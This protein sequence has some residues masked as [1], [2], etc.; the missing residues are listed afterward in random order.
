MTIRSLAA[1]LVTAGLASA[2]LLA[3]RPTTLPETLC[4][5][6]NGDG[7]I[8]AAD[9]LVTLKAGVGIGTCPVPVC[10]VT[11]DGQVRAADALRILKRAVG[12]S[13]DLLC[14]A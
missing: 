5:D 2:T 14:A 6:A 12:S 9:A 13:V 4:G 7:K 3:Q 1:L 10:D 11:G 8:T